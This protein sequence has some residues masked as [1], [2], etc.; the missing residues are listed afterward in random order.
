MLDN[1]VEFEAKGIVR[2]SCPSLIVWVAVAAALYVSESWLLGPG[3]PVD[4]HDQVGGKLPDKNQRFSVAQWKDGK[5]A[6]NRPCLR[7]KGRRGIGT[8]ISISGSPC[9][10][11][12]AV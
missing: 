11:A 2:F 9:G 4:N 3:D 7:R 10:F 5:G 6:E 1:G 12:L 8:V